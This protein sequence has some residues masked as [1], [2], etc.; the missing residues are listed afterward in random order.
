MTV[1]T[2]TGVTAID[3]TNVV[4]AYYNIGAGQPD[5]LYTVP[6]VAVGGFAV[7]ETA[8]TTIEPTITVLKTRNYQS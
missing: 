7:V 8:S 5:T 1:A 2:A 6:T 4:G 3:L